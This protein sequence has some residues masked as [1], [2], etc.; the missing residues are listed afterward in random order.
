MS[1]PDAFDEV[2]HE[3]DP[4]R[5]GRR[6]TEL[7]TLYQQRAT[8]LARLRRA[9]V[10]QAHRESG[11]SYT[12]IAAAFGLTKGRITQIRNTAPP[13][14]RAF[15][16]VGPVTIGVPWRYQTTDRERP[17]IAA[18]D[19]ATGDTLHRLLDSLGIAA[20]RDHIQPARETLPDGDIV[21]IC[22]PKSAPVAQRL[23]DRDPALTIASRTGRWFIERKDTGERLASPSDSTPTKRA[24][25]AYIGR[26]ETDGR[27]IVH[28]AGLHAIGSLG[29]ATYLEQHLAE[30]YKQV[31]GRS[32][33]LVVRAQYEGLT[34]TG[35]DVIA[36]PF[37]W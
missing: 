7:L 4:I 2:R 23:I 1:Q 10:D 6:A 13:P 11:L 35:S 15:F 21:L 19:A 22:G 20:T 33:S 28:V 27:V 3:P 32:A 31:E 12:E 25:L 26:H 5:R 30:L 8:E 16:G 34:I 29:A 14:E 18:E 37:T 24:D 36:G 17:L 9:A